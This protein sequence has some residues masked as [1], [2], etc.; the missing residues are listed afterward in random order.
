MADIYVSETF[1]PSSVLQCNFAGM[2]EVTHTILI[3]ML[4]SVYFQQWDIGLGPLPIM[5]PALLLTEFYSKTYPE[6]FPR[7]KTSC[8]CQLLSEET[9][10]LLSGTYSTFPIL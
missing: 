5:Y 6:V 10:H 4:Q 7:H 2:F 8:I 3:C 1:I 9:V